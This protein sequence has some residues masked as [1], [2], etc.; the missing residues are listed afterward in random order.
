MNREI[1]GT[2]TIG[3]FQLKRWND[4]IINLYLLIQQAAIF[5][6]DD[7]LCELIFIYLLSNIL[8][9]YI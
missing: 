6:H 2:P 9:E 7:T 3:I 8:S 5:W 4:I 1:V